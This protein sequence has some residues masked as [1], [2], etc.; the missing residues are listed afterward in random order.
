MSRNERSSERLIGLFCL[1]CILF[2]PLAL[3]IFDKGT[4]V[5]LAG[6]PVLVFYLF[7]AWACLVAAMAI[8]AN[9]IDMEDEAP[10]PRLDEAGPHRGPSDA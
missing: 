8:V 7:A 10:A 2:S 6:V 5:A 3:M 4:D 1:G 9:G